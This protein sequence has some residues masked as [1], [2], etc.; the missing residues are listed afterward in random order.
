M[1]HPLSF[2]PIALL[3]A[4]IVDG[5]APGAPVRSSSE[6]QASRISCVDA[7]PGSRCTM[8]MGDGDQAV[9]LSCTKQPSGAITCEPQ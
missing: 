4:A 6:A 5:C 1:P 9:T 2:G 8:P 7:L 3:L